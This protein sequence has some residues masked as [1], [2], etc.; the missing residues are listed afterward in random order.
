MGVVATSSAN[1]L[2]TLHQLADFWMTLAC[3]LSNSGTTFR[4]AVLSPP[5]QVSFSLKLNSTLSAFL[6]SSET[7]HPQSLTVI[8][9]E[10]SGGRRRPFKH[11]STP[12]TLFMDPHPAW[13]GSHAPVSP[14][15]FRNTGC[16]TEER[17]S[18][19]VPFLKW[20]G[21]EFTLRN[22]SAPWRFRPHVIRVSSM[23]RGEAT[24]LRAI[25][26][27]WVMGGEA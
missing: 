5:C 22:G 2:S 16:G 11:F 8:G 10:P 3:P 27:I 15:V 25:F 20:L 6:G 14:A 18:R 13:G 7:K 12:L 26:P 19:C 17:S 21:A 4:R 24:L 1:F 23:P 9:A